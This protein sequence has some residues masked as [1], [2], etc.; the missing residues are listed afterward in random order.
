MKWYSKLK[1]SIIKYLKSMNATIKGQY[2]KYIKYI[3]YIYATI[4]NKYMK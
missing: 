2:I 1:L 4:Y 3:E